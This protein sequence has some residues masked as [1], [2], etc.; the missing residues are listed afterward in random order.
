MSS[1]QIQLPAGIWVQVTTTDKQGSIR[2]HSG[3]TAIIYTEAPSQPPALSAA[4]PLWK[5]R[6]RGKTSL[7]LMLVP[8]I[9]FGLMPQAMMQLLPFHLE[10]INMPSGGKNSKVINVGGGVARQRAM[11]RLTAQVLVAVVLFLFYPVL[12]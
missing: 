2:H 5:P 8:L 12:S 1:I 3:N 10:D 9:L 7:I 4:T 6:L 11:T